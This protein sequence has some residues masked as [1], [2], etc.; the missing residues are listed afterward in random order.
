M[1]ITTLGIDV[2]KEVFQLCGADSV[3]KV[4]L[5]QRLPRNKLKE[6]VVKL[7]SCRI[8]MEA[9]GS[10]NYWAR[11]FKSMGHEV[12][13]IAPQ[14]VKPFV[15]GNKNDYQ[16]AEAIVEAASRPTMRYVS[17]KKIEQQDL[18]SLLRIREGYVETRIKVGNQIRGLLAEYGVVVKQG[19]SQLRKQLPKL[20]ERDIENG[21]TVK[22]KSLLERQYNFLLI[23]DEQIAC[24]DVELESSA[25]ENVV[26]QR[27]MGIEGVGVITAIG[28]YALVGDGKE[29]KNGRHLSAFLGLVPRQHSSGNKERLLGISRRGN[30]FVRRMFIHGARSAVL[31][32]SKKTDSRSLWIQQLKLR[33]GMN[34][35]CVAVANKNARIAMSML[36]SGEDYRRAV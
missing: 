36:L 26:C 33:A 30:D 29:F 3:G 20:F 8:V 17:P 18:Q 14:Y 2:A 27:L 25:K 34:R 22:M 32:S 16:D 5:K 12:N 11:V 35:A 6:Y 24:C 1:N 9:C 4:V 28:L 19:I 10:A 23:L 21:L 7:P 15:K 13:L 31:W